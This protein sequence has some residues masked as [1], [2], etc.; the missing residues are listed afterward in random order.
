M[1]LHTHLNYNALQGESESNF[2]PWLTP[3]ISLIDLETRKLIV[4]T[5][6]TF[7]FIYVFNIFFWKG[8]EWLT[9][10]YTL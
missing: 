7:V 6:I 3:N 4:G 2:S 1:V 5:F 10:I 9:K 8:T